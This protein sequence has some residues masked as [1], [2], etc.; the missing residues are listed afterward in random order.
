MSEWKEIQA[1]FEVNKTP[2]EIC[3]IRTRYAMRWYI[4]KANWNKRIYYIFSFI[5]II[6]PLANVVVASCG[7]INLA[8]VILASVTSLA[9]SLL[10]LTNARMKWENYRSAAEFLKR[11]YTLY[12]ARV[13]TYGDN[14]RVSAYLN[15]TEGFMGEV[16]SNWQNLFDKGDSGKEP[17]EKPGKPKDEK[18]ST[19]K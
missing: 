6:C 10:A 1:L 17:E 11:E 15:T 2:E 19:D 4:R 12:Q 13:G 16:H 14:Q 7:K 3:E 5:G 18:G 8:I 9:T